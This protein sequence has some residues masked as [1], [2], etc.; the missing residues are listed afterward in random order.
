MMEIKHR[1]TG[2][3]LLTVDADT[4]ID[5][6]LID[7][8]L[9]DADLRGADL[10][11][12]DLSGADL[13]GAILSD[14]DL[15]SACIKA[16]EPTVVELNDEYLRDTHVEGMPKDGD[17]CTEGCI[18]CDARKVLAETQ[19]PVGY[20]DEI[21]KTQ[22]WLCLDGQMVVAQLYATPPSRE[23]QSLSDEEIWDIAN[24]LGKNKEWDY[25]VMFAKT[26]EK[27][28]REKNG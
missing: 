9:I 14:A 25:P 15:R 28:L 13:R 12:A 16:L 18:K 17:C 10:S 5:A 6:I 19:E 2:E 20:V 11:G 8:I 21:I 26:I 3:V 23:W 22:H 7:A 27:V 1:Y 4:L 24:F